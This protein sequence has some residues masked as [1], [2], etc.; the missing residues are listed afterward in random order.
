MS[1]KP[2][3]LQCLCFGCEKNEPHY[4]LYRAGCII[5]AYHGQEKVSA[6]G[7]AFYKSTLHY[8]P[9][10]RSLTK[11]A[12]AGSY[13]DASEPKIKLNA[14]FFDLPSDERVKN[15]EKGVYDV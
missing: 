8:D 5:Y 14:E 11:M 6:F 3:P 9:R 1:T 12:H 4:E 13:K 15:L 7:V 10:T 2:D